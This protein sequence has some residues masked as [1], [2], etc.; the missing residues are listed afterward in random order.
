MHQT[1]LFMLFQRLIAWLWSERVKALEEMIGL[2]NL[3]IDR[4]SIELETVRAESGR[5]TLTS[6]LNRRG[7]ER[8]LDQAL[9]ALLRKVRSVGI[10]AVMIDLDGFKKINDTRGHPAGDA[11]LRLVAER[12]IESFR[13]SDIIIRLGGDEFGVILIDADLAGSKVRAETVLQRIERDAHGVTASIGIV[14]DTLYTETQEHAGALLG[15]L[16]A[17]A[18]AAMYQSKQSG[19]NRI[20]IASP[21]SL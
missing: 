14:A 19:K 6:L 13:Q 8:A 21:P 20:S 2:Q 17:A 3:E 15:R 9:G 1:S 4:L 10:V 5:D 12:L 11:L 16:I 7:A 18:D